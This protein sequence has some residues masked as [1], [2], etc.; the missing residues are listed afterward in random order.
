MDY[1]AK[2]LLVAHAPRAFTQFSS[3]LPL[4]KMLREHGYY[5]AAGGT[6]KAMEVEKIKAEGFDFFDVYIHDKINLYFDIK[7]VLKLRRILVQEKF[8]IINGQSAK[9]GI[10]ARLAGRLAN[11]PVVIQTVHAWPF[12][13]FVSPLNAV[14]YKQI[15]R[16]GAKYCDCIIVDSKE[17][18]KR[19][20]NANIC[21]PEKMR[22]VYM[23]IDTNKFIPADQEQRIYL[24]QKFNLQEQDYVVGCAARLVPGKGIDTLISAIAIVNEEC[25]SVKCLI[26]GD[27]ELEN[28]LRSQINNLGLQ[29]TCIMTGRIT[30]MPEFYQ[31]LDVFCLPTHREGFGVALAE[32]MSCSI[33]VVSTDVAPLDETV[34]D[35]QT[36]FLC[37]KDDVNAFAQMI[38]K[39]FDKK[40]RDVIA[41]K[42]RRFVC[43]N[44]KIDM[45][46]AKLLKIYESLLKEKI[47]SKGIQE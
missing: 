32:A 19:G 37:P 46:N 22:Q 11:T 15:E 44:F 14:L 12:H 8:D 27:G 17:V 39:L 35:G 33:P 25:S 16:I 30:N 31:C 38:L 7:S 20:I 36:G 13:D 42:A 34:L 43:E 5:V 41:T 1:K 9:P 10:I 24:R 47:K 21:L 28:E 26:A 23:G 18:Y 45:V 6:Y 40:L 4:M 29:K 2:I 3:G